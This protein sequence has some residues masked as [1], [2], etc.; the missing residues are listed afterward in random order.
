LY[1][2]SQEAIVRGAGKTSTETV[3]FGITAIFDGYLPVRQ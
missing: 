1:G 2:V 3:M